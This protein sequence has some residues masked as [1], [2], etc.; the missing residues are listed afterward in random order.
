MTT[1]GVKDAGDT[2]FAG[3]T[4]YLDLNNNGVR[5][6]GEPYTTTN[7]QGSFSFNHLAMGTYTVREVVPSGYIITTAIL[8]RQPGHRQFDDIPASA[9]TNAEDHRL[10]QQSIR[11]H[12][13]ARPNAVLSMSISDNYPIQDL[14]ITL[15]V[16]NNASTAH[17]HP[18]CPRRHARHAVVELR[19]QRH[20]HLPRARL[21][22]KNVSGTWT[23][24]VDGLA[25]GT[26]NNWSLSVLG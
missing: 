5:D 22:G 8:H 24:E 26:L 14:S 3:V 18:L 7:A 25:G 16:T 11:H 12:P 1:N 17:Y 19:G 13:Q 6:S 10:F 23:L 2:P 21:I 9:T 20:P 15:K 4:V